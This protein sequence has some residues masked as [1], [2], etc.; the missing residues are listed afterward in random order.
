MP[1]LAVV[2][3][4]ARTMNPSP[5]QKWFLWTTVVVS[6]LLLMGCVVILYAQCRPT[7]ALWEPEPIGEKVT[8]WSPEILVNYSIVVGGES[9]LLSLCPLLG[10]I[11]LTG[12]V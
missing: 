8:C 12:I 10:F 7:R 6:G 4:L 9:Y 1:K 11:L 5:R 2:T 3:L